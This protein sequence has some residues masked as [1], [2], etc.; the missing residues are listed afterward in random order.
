[1]T[2]VDLDDIELIEDVCCDRISS[3][4]CSDERKEVVNII[5]QEQHLRTPLNAREARDR[6][7]GPCLS[8]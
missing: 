5:M 2:D 7:C 1:M 3:N 8:Y 6:F 4:H